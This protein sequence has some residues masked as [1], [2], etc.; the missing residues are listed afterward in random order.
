MYSAWVASLSLA[1]TNRLVPAPGREVNFIQVDS[2]KLNAPVER[3]AESAW[4]RYSLL[5][6]AGLAAFPLIPVVDGVVALSV[7]VS[8]PK[9]SAR[10]TAPAPVLASFIVQ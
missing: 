1:A 7:R 4:E 5:A 10:L 8:E 6:A 2:E 3:A 9:E